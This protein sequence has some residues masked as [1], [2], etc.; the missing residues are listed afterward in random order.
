MNEILI[1][2]LLFTYSRSV[3][4]RHNISQSNIT[5]RA[6]K[7]TAE[8]G[9]STHDE[10]KKCTF[11]KT[12]DS[13]IDIKCMLNDT[14]LYKGCESS[15]KYC[16][17]SEQQVTGY[18]NT[19][20]LDSS[21]Y[22]ILF[23]VPHIGIKDEFEV[24]GNHTFTIQNLD[25]VDGTTVILQAI[26]EKGASV[27]IHIT[28]QFFPNISVAPFYTKEGK[29]QKPVSNNLKDRALFNNIH[30][31]IELPV[32]E[33]KGKS[34]IPQNRLK[35]IPDRSIP[36]GSHLFREAKTVENLLYR[37][38]LRRGNELYCDSLA[39]EGYIEGIGRMVGGVFYLTEV[40]MNEQRLTGY[41]LSDILNLTPSDIAQIE[42][43]LPSNY[44]MYGN[45][46]GIG[47]SVPIN[48]LYGQASI[49]GLLMIWT[50][51]GY[52]RRHDKNIQYTTIK[53]L[54]YMQQME[55][56]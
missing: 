36:E 45:L 56:Q 4:A 13:Y 19:S 18:V 55:K 44:E 37:F 34:F 50:K 27:D 49:R 38:G 5:M 43:F 31:S 35:R 6:T 48:G 51:S 52:V 42:Y 10:R 7:H 32:V 15:M 33:V 46:A 22:K 23:F 1:A 53:P 14:S 2:L 11:E 12:A 30:S 41:E 9:S 21:V 26:S 25:I 47:K 40:I 24:I 28:P 54:G 8:S 17:E 39:G 16:Y 20:D 3:S 29:I